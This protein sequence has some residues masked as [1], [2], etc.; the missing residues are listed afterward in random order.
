MPLEAEGQ[1]LIISRLQPHTLDVQLYQTFAHMRT[2]AVVSQG[3]NLYGRHLNAAMV[4]HHRVLDPSVYLRTAPP[5]V[6]N[7]DLCSQTRSLFILPC[8]AGCKLTV[9]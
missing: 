6:F 8:A 4:L 2:A 1:S 7:R 3:Y 9:L 5:S